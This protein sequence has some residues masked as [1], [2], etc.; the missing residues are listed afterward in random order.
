MPARCWVHF[1]LSEQLRE[2]CVIIPISQIRKLRLA[3]VC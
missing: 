3:E 1:S 2:V